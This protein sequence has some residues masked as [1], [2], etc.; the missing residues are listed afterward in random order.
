MAAP[1]IQSSRR[2]HIASSDDARALVGGVLK[3]LQELEG[4]LTLE[5]DLL[6]RGHLRQG[7]EYEARKSELGGFYMQ[8]LENIKANAVALA[9][10]A[11]DQIKTLRQAHHNFED[12]LDLNQTVL[13]TTKAISEGLVK[14]LADEVSKPDRPTTYGATGLNTWYA[15]KAEP[16]LVSKKL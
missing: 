12:V 15:S 14:T 4:I 9:R 6:S 10:L 11:P 7:L 13:A 5:T 1:D 2:M 8:G 16:L 3:T